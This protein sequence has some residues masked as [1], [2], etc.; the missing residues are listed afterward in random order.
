MRAGPKH[1][2]A[3]SVRKQLG[4]QAYDISFKVAAV[5]GPIASLSWLEDGDWT[6]E[7]ARAGWKLRRG[8]EERCEV[9]RR[10]GV[11]RI[12]VDD[13]GNAETALRL[14]PFSADVDDDKPHW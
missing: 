10:D 11:Y 3:T 6:F 5:S 7:S 14:C 4:N 9:L 8:Q 1:F 2:G 13:A 12:R